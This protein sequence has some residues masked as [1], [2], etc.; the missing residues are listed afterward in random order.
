MTRTGIL[1]VLCLTLVV[2]KAQPKDPDW[3]ETVYKIGK[4]YP[5]FYV[6]NTNDTIHGYFLHDDKKGNQK[7]CRFYTNEMDKKPTAEFKPEDIKSY[8]VADK[9]KKHG[10]GAAGFSDWWAYKFE[11]YEAIP[12]NGAILHDQ[13]VVTAFN[14]DDAEMASNYP[15]VQLTN[16]QGQVFYAKSFNWRPGLTTP[17]NWEIGGPERDRPRTS[18]EACPTFPAGA[19]EL[20]TG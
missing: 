1:I 7:K 19:F 9:L 3:S 14:S 15:I 5:G 16:P 20:A 10:A 4:I 2:A 12:Y 17:P 8:K 18:I 6:T 13:G 11:V